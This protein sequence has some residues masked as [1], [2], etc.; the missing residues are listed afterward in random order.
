MSYF[1]IG[2]FFELLL[3]LLNIFSSHFVFMKNSG[4]EDCIVLT[5]YTM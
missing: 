5:T 3:S 4:C 1:N 2:G